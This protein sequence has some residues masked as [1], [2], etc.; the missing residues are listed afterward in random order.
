ME[1]LATFVTVGVALALAYAVVRAYW[2]GSDY[3]FNDE[4][5]K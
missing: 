1:L 3:G 2:Q 4:L 5:R